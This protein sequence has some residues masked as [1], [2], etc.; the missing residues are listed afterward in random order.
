MNN[1]PVCYLQCTTVRMARE[2]AA[3]CCNIHI[4]RGLVTKLFPMQSL[5]IGAL[6]KLREALGHFS[7]T[8]KMKLVPAQIKAHST[9]TLYTCENENSEKPAVI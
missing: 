4:A 3:Q 2:G 7:H 8:C 1:L 9:I 6:Q 5:T